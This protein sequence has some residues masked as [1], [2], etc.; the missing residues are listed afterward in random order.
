MPEFATLRLAGN[1]DHKFPNGAAFP[2][3]WQVL[4]RNSLTPVAWFFNE[5]DALAYATLRNAAAY[6]D[7]G[8][9]FMAGAV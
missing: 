8:H 7:M 6:P 5:V 1:A 4:Q 3:I 9:P 2:P